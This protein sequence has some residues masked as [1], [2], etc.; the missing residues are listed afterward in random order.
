[1]SE[2]KT[3]LE[4]IARLTKEIDA[5]ARA[6]DSVPLKAPARIAEARGAF[7]DILA[8]ARAAELQTI[9][10][11]RKQS[12]IHIRRIRVRARQV[13]AVKDGDRT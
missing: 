7:R 6:V 10:G 4:T 12:L 3:T 13:L 9:A 5:L 11:N 1:M 8:A 2:D